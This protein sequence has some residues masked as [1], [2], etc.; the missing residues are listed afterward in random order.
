MGTRQD[1]GIILKEMLV[2]TNGDGK[3]AGDWDRKLIQEA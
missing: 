2:G 3:E 1:E